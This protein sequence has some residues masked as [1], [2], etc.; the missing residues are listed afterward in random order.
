MDR[1]QSGSV[2]IVG[3][4][5][6]GSSDGYTLISRTPTRRIYLSPFWLSTGL[7]ASLIYFSWLVMHSSTI[8][9]N[10]IFGIAITIAGLWLVAGPLLVRAWHNRLEK[11]ATDLEADPTVDFPRVDRP[12]KD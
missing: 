6:D 12:F 11:L 3:M 9:H 2:K 10:Q 8:F 1:D 7:V 4:R 5:I